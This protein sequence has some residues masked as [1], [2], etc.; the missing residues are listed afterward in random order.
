MYPL[1]L[2]VQNYTKWH[3]VRRVT[4]DTKGQGQKI[5]EVDLIPDGAGLIAISDTMVG[6][7]MF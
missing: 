5:K 4:L 2:V 3:T 7:G 6:S 1:Q